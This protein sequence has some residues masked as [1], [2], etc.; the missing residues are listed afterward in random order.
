MLALKAVIWV[1]RTI[2]DAKV[3]SFKLIAD[4]AAGAI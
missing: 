1:Y 3:M 2:T 4:S